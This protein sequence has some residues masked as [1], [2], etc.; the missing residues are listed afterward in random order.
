MELK[1]ARQIISLNLL[2]N[3]TTF[4]PDFIQSLSSAIKCIDFVDQVL[5]VYPNITFEH[6]MTGFDL[7]LQSKFKPLDSF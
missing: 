1:K 5:T 3:R 6:L 2:D 4:S 7:Y